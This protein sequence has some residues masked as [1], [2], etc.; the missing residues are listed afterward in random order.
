MLR[1]SGDVKRASASFSR[2]RV[3]GVQNLANL[4]GQT[5]RSKRL[6]QET[7]HV[8]VGKTFGSLRLA[9]A[10]HE[11]HRDPLAQSPD[12]RDY[13]AVTQVARGEIDAW[14]KEQVKR[15]G[16]SFENERYRL[17]IVLPAYR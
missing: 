8:L 12:P 2:L 4:S 5:Q 6:L 9:I 10:A 15:S 11:D 14:L 17:A 7:L 16:G 13:R 3:T 1:R